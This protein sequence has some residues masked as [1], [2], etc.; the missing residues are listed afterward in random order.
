MLHANQYE[1]SYQPTEEGNH[2]LQITVDSQH[3]Y[4]SPF[5]LQV[6]RK[7]CTQVA[8]LDNVQHPYSVVVDR[9]GRVITTEMDKHSVS[10]FSSIVP[11]S[12]STANLKRAVI[13]GSFTRPK[14]L[15]VDSN[16][17]IFVVDGDNHRIKKF[18]AD[19]RHLSTVGKEGSRRLEFR[20]PSGIAIHPK[21]GRIYI[22]DTC[23]H[24][25][26]ILNSN[27]TFISI[28]GSNGTSDGKF[29]YPHDVAFDSGG[30][31]YV[32]D[33]SNHRIQVFEPDGKCLR[34]FG[35]H[36]TYDGE[37]NHPI[38]ISVDSRKKDVV[39]VTDKDNHR[40][41]M[42][43][44]E[45]KFITSFGCVGS[46][47]GQFNLPHGITAKNGILYVCDFYNNRVQLFQ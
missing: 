23:N 31:V 46:G 14:G 20:Y 6:F 43:T 17:N 32:I 22:T 39:Y 45:G 44:S 41:S 38:A 11:R 29:S 34:I 4:G 36:G 40:I 19:R 8:S 3:I 26:Q 37:L 18:T 24:C 7:P 15:A 2:S 1:I 33:N 28:F 10:I 13:S 5:T 30:N 21:S 25:I 9:N 42:F 12:G 16:N 27:L 35:K 47:P